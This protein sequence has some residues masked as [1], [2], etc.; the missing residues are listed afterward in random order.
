ML[1]RQ[2][3]LRGVYYKSVAVPARAADGENGRAQRGPPPQAARHDNK[4]APARRRWLGRGGF[5]V[6]HLV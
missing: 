3:I 2:R 1:V 4:T 5:A 6:V